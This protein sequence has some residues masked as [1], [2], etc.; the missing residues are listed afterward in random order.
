MEKKNF[1]FVSIDGLITDVAWQ[2]LKEGHNVKYSIENKEER[3]VGDGFVPKVDDWKKEV[4]WADVIIFDDVL[5]QG[6]KAQKLREE[7]KNVIGG[8]PYTDRLEDDRA[9]GQDELKKHGIPTIPS[10]NFTNFDEAISFVQENPDR[11]VIKPSGEVQISKGLLF[12]GE[13][14]DGKDVVR[15]LEDYKKAWGKKI[16]AFQLQKRVPGVEVAVGAFFNGKDFIYPINVNFEHKKLFPGNIGPSTGEMGC[17]DEKTEVLT[18]KG[19]KFFKD[20]SYGDE[21]CT[22]N[23][24][25]EKEY[26]KPTAI[27]SFNHH[28]KLLSIHNQTLDIAV[29]PDHNMYVCSQW[30]ARN[31]KHEFNFV[32]ARDLQNQSIIKRTGRW[33][34]KEVENFVLPSVELGHYEGRQVVLHVA[35][36][37]KIPMN[38]WLAFMGIWI[39]DGFVS[40]GYKVGISQKNQEKTGMIESLLQKLP[41]EFTKGKNEFYIYNKQVSSYLEQFGKAPEKYVPEFVKELS[42]EQIGTFLK[43]YCLGDGTIMEGGYRIFYT[44]SKKLADDVQELL[45]KI[46][47]VGVVKERERNGEVWIKDHYA[48]SARVQYEVHERVKKL[49]SWIDQRDIKEVDYD[50][51]VY[52]AT[53]KNHVMYVRRNG[54]PYWC[55]NTTMFWSGPNSLFNSTL[56]KFEPKLKEEKYVGYIDINCI[57]NS[58]GIYPLEWTS[59]FGYPTIFIQHEGMLNPIGEFMYGMSKGNSNKLKT[60]SGFQMGVRV[61]VPPFPFRDQE[62]FNVYSKDTIILFKKPIKEGVH[63]EDVKLF[64]DEWVITGTSGVVLVV[65]GTGSTMKSAQNQTYNRINNILIPNMY[66]RKDVGDRWHDDSDWLHNWGYLREV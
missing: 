61:V 31:G 62:T 66:Y 23:P 30:S 10:W 15:L 43:W 36:E 4:D 59:R 21:I 63:I 9:F 54:K 26:P 50:E 47:R 35:Q 19:W 2:I 3:E 28:K 24:S 57:V 16:K 49:D 20:L 25:D 46:G 56:K 42:S 39:S 18:D 6:R 1:L 58:K 41:F 64:N 45:L 13:E 7:G 14:E 34:G 33:I 55:G 5:G 51:K 22:L 38:D 27:V 29:T 44:S 53:V 37:M 8:T 60:K 11:Y 17:Y 32:K 52:C 65:C 40:E 12:V 48:R